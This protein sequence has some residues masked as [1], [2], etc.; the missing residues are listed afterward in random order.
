M[1]TILLA[2]GLSERMGRNKLLLPY[3]NSSII[4][5]T[6]SIAL[7]FSERVIVVI[8]NEKEKIQDQLSSLPLDFVFNKNYIQGQKSS[9][10]EGL[11]AVENDDFAIL[12]G[13][14][15]LLSI[16]DGISVKEALNKETCARC[17]FFSI[18]GHPV[19]YRRE[20]RERLL[21]YPGTMKSYLKDVGFVSVPSSLGSIY[22]VDTPEKYKLLLEADGDLSVLESNI[23]LS[24][25]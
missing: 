21:T 6:A 18:P 11:K 15:P 16:K 10:M 5:H 23:D 13:D 24:F 20:N 14:L 7:G 2:A 3:K 19:A 22:D 17:T 8:G 9:I 1:T 4:F 25:S 12:P